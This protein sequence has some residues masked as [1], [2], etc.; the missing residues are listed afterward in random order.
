MAVGIHSCGYR[1]LP[2][3]YAWQWRPVLGVRL[4][5]CRYIAA[6]ARHEHTQSSGVQQ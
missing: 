3:L 2:W 1:G 6:E 5:A 4:V